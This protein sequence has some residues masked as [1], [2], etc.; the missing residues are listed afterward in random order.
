MKGRV[1]VVVPFATLSVQRS[2]CDLDDV[3]DFSVEFPAT[4]QS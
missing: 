2:W 3:L 4:A 1:C